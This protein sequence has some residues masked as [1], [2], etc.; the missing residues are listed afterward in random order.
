MP[1][2]R[3]F[4]DTALTGPRGW[5]LVGSTLYGAYLDK[6]VTIDAGGTVIQLTGALS[7]ALPVSWARN[8]TAP[9]PDIVAVSENGA[10][11]VTSPMPV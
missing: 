9:V 4:C 7:G 3:Y 11:T 5:L 10:F 8:N 6:A 1:G 2:L